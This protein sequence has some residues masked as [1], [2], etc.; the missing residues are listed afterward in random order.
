MT[1]EWNI[2]TQGIYCKVCNKI[3]QPLLFFNSQKTVELFLQSDTI[4]AQFLV[5][6]YVYGG[7][8]L[9]LKFV[10][11]LSSFRCHVEANLGNF[12]DF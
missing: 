4:V 10:F 8:R 2:L 6:I 1:A 12:S 7:K 9:N 3:T 11:Q 5:S